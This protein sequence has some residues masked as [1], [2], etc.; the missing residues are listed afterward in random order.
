MGRKILVLTG[1][2]RKGGNSD[3]L[4]EAFIKG[5]M[6]KGH[7]TTKFECGYKSI[8]PCIACN[9]CYTRTG[10]CVFGDDFNQLAPL[11][12]LSDMIVFAT[13]LYWYTFSAQ[14]K[15]GLDKLYALF[16]GGRQ[17]LI[18][19]SMLLACG[20][21]KEESDYEGLIK[22]YQIIAKF[23]KW[24]DA[25]ILVAPAVSDIGDIIKTDFLKKA[26]QMGQAIK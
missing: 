11:L 3:L 18:Q 16:I 9:A 19:D 21:T 22:T 10:A 14:L 8:K 24:N 1:S 7:E 15:A 23:N 13:P 5:A 2:P 17:S 6:A 20:E 4:A 26:E 25:G 12:E